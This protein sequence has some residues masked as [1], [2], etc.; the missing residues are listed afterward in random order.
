VSFRTPVTLAGEI[1]RWIDIGV[2]SL[3]AE[4]KNVPLHH[5][6]E[7]FRKV[8]RTYDRI[9]LPTYIGFSSLFEFNSDVIPFVE[10]F[11]R[12]LHQTFIGAPATPPLANSQDAQRGPSQQ[13]FVEP[14]VL[15]DPLQAVPVVVVLHVHLAIGTDDEAQAIPGLARETVT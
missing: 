5:V 7:D 9:D 12:P 10:P 8:V 14:G 1:S 3:H 6:L 2:F 13:V 15:Q 4:V 11:S